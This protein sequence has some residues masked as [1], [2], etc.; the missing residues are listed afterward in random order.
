MPPHVFGTKYNDTFNAITRANMNLDA[1]G[2]IIWTRFES[3]ILID[4]FCLQIKAVD[5]TG[6]NHIIEMMYATSEVPVNFTVFKQSNTME[7][8]AADGTPRF[9]ISPFGQIQT[10]SINTKETTYY[11]LSINNNVEILKPN[12]SIV[13]ELN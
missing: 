3:T 2:K 11:D 5:Q 7:I 13:N 8:F 6:L 12:V 9:I 1:D 4:N 10:P